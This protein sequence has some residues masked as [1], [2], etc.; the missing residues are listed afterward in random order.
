M[1]AR[2]CGWVGAR[3]GWPSRRP[4]PQGSPAVESSRR[5]WSFGGTENW[6][7]WWPAEKGAP[8]FETTRDGGAAVLVIRA[9]AEVVSLPYFEPHLKG[10]VALHKA[11]GFGLTVELQAG[12]DV[13]ISPLHIDAQSELLVLRPW[14]LAAGGEPRR[15]ACPRSGLPS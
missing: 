2:S 4:W 15:P 5:L 6:T 3:F 9:T 1:G 11:I 7:V 8:P 13:T 12:R 14:P 10:A